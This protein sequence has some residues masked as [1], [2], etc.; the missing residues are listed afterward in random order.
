MSKELEKKNIFSKM[1]YHMAECMKSIIPV[2]VASGLMK[3]IILFLGYT[4]LFGV[5]PDTNVICAITVVSALLITEFVTK[6][7]YFTCG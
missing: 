7:T 5:Y 2:L 6:I 3:I 1:I 4:S